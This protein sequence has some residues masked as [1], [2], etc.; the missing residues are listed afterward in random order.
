MAP[1]EKGGGAPISLEP[2]V[3]YTSPDPLKY[4]PLTE[5]QIEVLCR[6][7]DDQSLNIALASAGAAAGLVQN[8]YD[9][10]VA[11]SDG[12]APAGRDLFLAFLC[13]LAAGVCAAK[14]SEWRRNK[15]RHDAA[16]KRVL[17]RASAP[18]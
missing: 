15:P 5:E 8:V 9:V 17:E 6:G 16:R 1:P 4:H 12:K 7:A 3:S 13:L 2:A 10:V 14:A 11:V 18:L